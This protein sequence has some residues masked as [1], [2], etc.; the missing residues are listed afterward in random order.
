MTKR[1]LLTAFALAPAPLPLFAFFQMLK[2][3]WSI[4]DAALVA[5]IYAACTYGSALLGGL[6]VYLT[7]ERRGWKAW[8]HYALAGAAIGLT[9]LAVLLTVFGEWGKVL[10]LNE[11]VPG[12][13]LGVVIPGAASAVLFWAIAIRRP[14][15][16]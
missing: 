13:T 15:A 3:W 16:A 6:P 7:F 5:G 1:R 14:R 8:W 11:Q 4:S 12:L 2:P 10:S 9:A